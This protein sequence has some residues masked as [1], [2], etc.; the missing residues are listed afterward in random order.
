MKEFDE[1][2]TRAAPRSQ[3]E[4]YEPY[5]A[6]TAHSDVLVPLEQAAVLGIGIGLLFILLAY[7][8]NWQADSRGWLL[9]FAIPCLVVTLIMFFWRMG[10]IS[11][12]TLYKAETL[13]GTDINQDGEVGEPPHPVTVNQKP[14]ETEIDREKKLLERF[15]D[16][17]YQHGTD[18]RT[19][20]NH[21][22]TD[23]QI[24]RLRALLIQPNIG[25]ARWNDT[26][27]KGGWKLI[28]PRDQANEIVRRLLWLP[29]Q[30]HAR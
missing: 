20:R 27:R 24:V 8:R 28:V 22:F 2:T 26:S 16:A 13:T 23:G 30:K 15:L 12:N 10:W 4:N 7:W 21:G 5:R 29:A 19:L 1:V 18:T 6:P 17:C 14:G 25:I 3:Q 11:E 9:L